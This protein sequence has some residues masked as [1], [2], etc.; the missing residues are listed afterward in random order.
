MS[1]A[2]SSSTVNNDNSSKFNP[3]LPNELVHPY[4]LDKSI[5]NFLGV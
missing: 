5:S 1:G 3:H 4:Q 2:S